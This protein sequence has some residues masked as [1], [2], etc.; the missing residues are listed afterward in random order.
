MA[1]PTALFAEKTSGAV[2]PGL[3]AWAFGKAAPRRRPVFAKNL[4]FWRY[5]PAA[6]LG[7]RAFARDF[8]K[9]GPTALFCRKDLQCHRP[10]LVPPGLLARKGLG[11]LISTLHCMILSFLDSMWKL[12]FYFICFLF[13]CFVFCFFASR[14]AILI[15][16]RPE[17][18]CLKP[19]VGSP[20]RGR[21][22][23]Q[24]PHLWDSGPIS[25]SWSRM[26]L[27]PSYGSY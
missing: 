8:G 2:D 27:E 24:W 20:A 9:A 12:C 17:N 19:G 5:V 18:G 11:F 3:F 25:C 26:V 7:L 16:S 1:G 10:W 4:G 13:V 22:E 15:K 6:N 14:S 21:V 23:G